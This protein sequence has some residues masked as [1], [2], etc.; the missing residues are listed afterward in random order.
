MIIC[1]LRIIDLNEIYKLPPVR[2]V[3]I[4]NVKVVRGNLELQQI[5]QEVEHRLQV[6]VDQGQY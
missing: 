6:S 5:K 1:I 4:I 2:T 3:I